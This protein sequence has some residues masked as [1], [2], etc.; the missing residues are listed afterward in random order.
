VRFL[1]AAKHPPGGRLP[2]GG[3]QSWCLTMAAA[4]SELG[5]EVTCWGPEWPLPDGPFDAGI[6]AH[7]AD[8]AAAWPLCGRGL[9]LSHGLIAAEALP[10]RAGYEDL[11]TAEEVRAHWGGQGALLRQ[12]IDLE[13]WSPVPV[14]P[15]PRLVRF[16]YYGGLAWLPKLAQSLGLD[17]AHLREDSPATCRDQIRHAAVV[18]A[19]GRAA[20]EAMACGVPV[21][22]ADE[23]PYQGPLL[24]P[25]PVG[26]MTRNY[27][28]RGG[29]KATPEALSA[30]L[31]AAQARGS[32]RPHV[33]WHHD[34]R[35]IAREVLCRLT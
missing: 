17:F 31:A 14:T 28:G 22:L 11:Y 13:F 27:S 21:V 25:D 10:P 29:V 19:S 1:L 26:A 34:A 5:H 9:R 2:I 16:G 8:T 4:L 35:Q 15:H 24:D 12:P 33:V 7:W 30:A 23:R 3:V 18:V 6:F 20:L 32:L